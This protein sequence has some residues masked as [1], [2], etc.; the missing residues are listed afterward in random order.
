MCRKHAAALSGRRGFSALRLYN[1]YY[2]VNRRL[3]KARRK[4]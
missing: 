3:A 2:A 4:S 1:L